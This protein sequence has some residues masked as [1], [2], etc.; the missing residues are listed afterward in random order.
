MQPSEEIKQKLDIVDVLKEYIQLKPAGMNF[1][2]ICPFH[3]EKTPSFMVSPD[4]QIYHCFGCGKSGDIFSFVMEIE[5]IDFREALRVLAPKAGVALR[6]VDPKVQSQRN[7]IM[8]ILDWSRRYYY[9]QLLSSKEASQAREYLKKRGLS[10]EAIEEWQIGYS[11]DSWDSTINFLKAKGYKEDEIA[12]AGMSAKS[13]KSNRYYD[14]FRGRIMFPINDVS[15]NTV[16]FSARVSPDKEETEKMGKYINSPQTEVYDKSKIVFGLDKAKMEIKKKDQ[17][18]IVEGQMDAI[19]AQ[20][21]GWKN[22]VA[23]SGTA[24]TTDQIQLLKRYSENIAL[25]FDQDSAGSMAADRGIK[26]AMQSE[27][28]IKVIELPEGM[29]PDDVIRKDKNIWIKAIENAKSMMQYN[30]D[31]VFG[32]LDLSDPEDKRRAAQR[33]LPAIVQIGSRIEQDYWIKYLANELDV[34][35]NLLRETIANVKKLAGRQS[36]QTEELAIW[37][38]PAKKRE[39][40]MS[41]MILA[42]AIKFPQFI[43][44]IFDNLLP[45]QLSEKLNQ[46][47]YK[48]I[49]IYYN[50]IVANKNKA[51][52]ESVDSAIFDY[53]NFSTYLKDNDQNKNQEIISAQIDLLNRLVFLSDEAYSDLEEDQIKTEISK[54]IKFLKKVSLKKKMKKIEILIAQAE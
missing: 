19:T 45:E 33:L 38:K 8:D 41:E 40:A 4:K 36:N 47:L 34:A 14:R 37:A 49:I 7:R 24:L 43:V 1:R 23:S 42:F 9:E 15:C 11:P 32:A 28:S 27:M 51:S 12:L 35:E 16:A 5:G 20:V 50:N 2:A 6:R 53:K 3:R 48:E 54:I 46:T 26:T 44:Y 22:V 18:I 52:S 30:F 25:A 13:N 39:E 10:K 17:A 21:A 29:D 31:R